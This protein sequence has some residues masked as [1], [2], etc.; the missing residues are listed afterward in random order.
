M[1]LQKPNAVH[2]ASKQQST[3]A[4]GEVHVLWG[5]IHEWREAEQEDW[6]TNW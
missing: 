4:S 2:A 3:A 6:Y 1:S 5:G